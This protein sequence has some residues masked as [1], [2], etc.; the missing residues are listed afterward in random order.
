MLAIFTCPKQLTQ[1][2]IN[3]IHIT[4]YVI[5]LYVNKIIMLDLFELCVTKR[6]RNNIL[7]CVTVIYS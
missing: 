3:S 7:Q 1:S 5:H 4:R 2:T 6:I